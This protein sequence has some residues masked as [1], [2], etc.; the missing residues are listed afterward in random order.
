MLKDLNGATYQDL[1]NDGRRHEHFSA[2]ENQSVRTVIVRNWQKEEVLYLIFH[3]LNTGSVPLSPQE[4]RQALHP[5]SFLKFVAKYSET[6]TAVQRV[7]G[8]SKPDFRM[9]DVELLVRYFAFRN[10]ISEYSGN[11]KQFLDDTCKEFNKHWSAR[12]TEIEAQAEDFDA[13]VGVTFA[14]FG[15]SAFRKWDGT[16]YERRFNRAVFDIMTY[17]F[18]SEAV[19][20]KAVSSK[21]KVRSSFE[22]LCTN[23]ADFR[24]AI[25]T[26]TK[27]KEATSTRFRD[28]GTAV[29]KVT[30]I[31]LEL[32][33]ISRQK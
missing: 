15:E 5:G 22:Q 20:K 26:T 24:R 3:R 10:R 17:Y 19:R 4:L 16:A 9:R 11:L 33:S 8:L 12:K 6:S 32:P 23:N 29:R 13:A 1:S 14:L 21:V 30:G 31:S 2:F 18:S 25:E 27:S 28:W 7:L